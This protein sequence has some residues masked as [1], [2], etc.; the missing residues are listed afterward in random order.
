MTIK[1]DLGDRHGAEVVHE[2]VLRDATEAAQRHGIIT[3]V[4]AEGG[5]LEVD[6]DPI[7][8][9]LH[10]TTTRVAL[11]ATVVT[12]GVTVDVAAVQIPGVAQARVTTVAGGV[13]TAVA[14][15]PSTSTPLTNFFPK[16]FGFRLFKF[17]PVRST[18]FHQIR[19][20]IFQIL[21]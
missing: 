17:L 2:A 14:A 20:S 12:T 7:H 4:V 16:F 18:T 10:R 6:P 3:G 13:P 11:D 5:I 9:T 1:T 8:L 15:D 21:I 19:K